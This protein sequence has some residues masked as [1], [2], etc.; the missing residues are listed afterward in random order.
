MH[1]AANKTS[2]PSGGPSIRY[3]IGLMENSTTNY[4]TQFIE[5]GVKNFNLTARYSDREGTTWPTASLDSGY[6]LVKDSSSPNRR[7]YG[8]IVPKNYTLSHDLNNTQVDAT[9]FNNKEIINKSLEFHQSHQHSSNQWTATIDVTPGA[10]TSR[11]GH[12]N[13]TIE[14]MKQVSQAED[15]LFFDVQHS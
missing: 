1:Q 4:T 8:E 11:N 7:A 9:P 12:Q 3:S 15:S 14:D 13:S 2:R 10:K 6:G 5:N